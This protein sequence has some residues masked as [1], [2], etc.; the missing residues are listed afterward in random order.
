M[1]AVKAKVWLSVHLVDGTHQRFPVAG[2]EAPADA[3]EAYAKQLAGKT[4]FRVGATF[5]PMA[6]IVRFEFVDA[7]SD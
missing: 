1:A 3:A 4:V 5:F 7:V 2:W 6:S